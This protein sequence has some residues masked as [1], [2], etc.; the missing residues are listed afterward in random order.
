MYSA[1]SGARNRLEGDSAGRPTEQQEGSTVG[2]GQPARTSLQTAGGV[3]REERPLGESSA[4]SEAH[5]APLQS[6]PGQ[7]TDLQPHAGTG[8]T[9]PGEAGAGDALRVAGS[10]SHEEEL[11]RVDG[12]DERSYEE[13][14]ALPAGS[15]QGQSSREAA[16]RARMAVGRRRGKHRTQQ[17]GNHR[18]DY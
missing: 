13:Q 9:V 7:S 10:L 2:S 5:E 12:G 18:P 14:E 6:A 1:G 3:Q 8:V 17:R 15:E 11:S 4:D 16:G